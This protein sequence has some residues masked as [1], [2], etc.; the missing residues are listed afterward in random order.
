MTK[1][2]LQNPTKC[3]CDP[4]CASL[5]YFFPGI[6]LSQFRLLAW[7]HMTA[8]CE[9]RERVEQHEMRLVNSRGVLSL[10][11]FNCCYLQ[12]ALLCRSS[13]EGGGH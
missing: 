8:P 10:F 1:P 11:F 3:I 9:K 6:F 4:N 13:R 5:F 12:M 7:L 2:P